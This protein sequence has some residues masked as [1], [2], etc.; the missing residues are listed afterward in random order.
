MDSASLS[1]S[2][3]SI[4]V[5]S[6]YL[7]RERPARYRCKSIGALS[8]DYWIRCSVFETRLKYLFYVVACFDIIS[9]NCCLKSSYFS[10]QLSW[11][12]RSLFFF[13]FVARCHF[14]TLGKLSL[15][16]TFLHEWASHWRDWF[17]TWSVL[18]RISKLLLLTV[19]PSCFSEGLR[20][21]LAYSRP[22]HKMAAW[23]DFY[24]FSHHSELVSIGLGR[25][26]FDDERSCMNCTNHHRSIISRRIRL[27]LFQFTCWRTRHTC[28][29]TIFDGT[30]D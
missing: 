19:P 15:L 10:L 29:V 24:Y 5:F 20:A 27:H 23:Q 17:V 4:S 2:I 11:P 8:F 28:I 30:Y 26:G 9:L 6:S 1:L 13:S 21:H 12:L 7:W 16:F 14:L 22:W 18:G 25:H 3:L